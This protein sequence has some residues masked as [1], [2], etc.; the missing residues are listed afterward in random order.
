MTSC[1]PQQLLLL[2]TTYANHFHY[3]TGVEEGGG[4]KMGG[5]LEAGEMEGEGEG[6]GEGGGLLLPGSVLR[7]GHKWT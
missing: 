2:S 4:V 7:S 5:R 3:L 6:E 1:H